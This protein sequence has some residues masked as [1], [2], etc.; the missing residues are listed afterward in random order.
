MSL[1][2]ATM[3]WMSRSIP[4]NLKCLKVMDADTLDMYTKQPLIGICNVSCAAMS[5][6]LLFELS[7]RVHARHA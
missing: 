2:F 5:E 1:E 6:K 7:T 4:S 3:R